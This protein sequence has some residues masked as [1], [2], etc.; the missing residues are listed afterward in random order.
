ML[1]FIRLLEANNSARNIQQK[2]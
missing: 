2:V 1:S